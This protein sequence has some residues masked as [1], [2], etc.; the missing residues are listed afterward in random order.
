MRSLHVEYSDSNDDNCILYVVVVIG[1]KE[2]VEGAPRGDN[3]G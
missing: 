3:K 1:G 2:I